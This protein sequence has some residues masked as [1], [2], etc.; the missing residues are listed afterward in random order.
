M[1]IH[2]ILILNIITGHNQ[3]R[4]K[5]NLKMNSNQLREINK[6]K[7]MLKEKK[8]NFHNKKNLYKCKISS[9][10]SLVLILLSKVKKKSH[11]IVL[12][13]LAPYSE[14]L[15]VVIHLIYIFERNVILFF[16]SKTKKNLIFLR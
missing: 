3:N 7:F 4:I 1:R 13:A 11:S 16:M 8:K 10:R 9:T 14:I 12:I 2:Y 6:F 15:F 5:T